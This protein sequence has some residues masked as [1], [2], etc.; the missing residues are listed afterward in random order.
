MN[1]HEVANIQDDTVQA[2]S[3]V[4]RNSGGQVHPGILSAIPH[5]LVCMC[6]STALHCNTHMVSRNYQHHQDIILSQHS[7]PF[8]FIATAS[9]LCFPNHQ[10][11]LFLKF[12][13]TNVKWNHAN[14]LLRF[15]SHSAVFKKQNF[16]ST[17]IAKH[18]SSCHKQSPT[19]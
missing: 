17:D 15:F 16:L 10:S 19:L 5:T 7:L 1:S 12:C 13:L 11:A 14:I 4:I 6:R 8:S 9:L 3:S 18:F 2:S